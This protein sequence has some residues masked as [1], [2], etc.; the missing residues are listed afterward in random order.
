MASFV[1]TQAKLDVLSGPI[2]LIEISNNAGP[3]ELS[4]GYEHR[5]EVGETT[6]DECLK[7]A[8][9][10][11]LGGNGGNIL[12]IKGGFT[13]SEFF[14]EGVLPILSGEK[15]AEQLDLEFAYRSADYD[16]VGSNNT[17]KLGASWRPVDNLLVRVMQQSAT[18]A[19]NV[20]EIASPVV[21]GLSNALIDPCSIAN[22]ENIDA[23]LKA[24]CISTGMSDAQVGKVQDIISGQVNAIQGTNPDSLPEAEEATTFTAGF[25]YSNDTLLDLSLS[26]DYYDIEV[27]NTIGNFTAQQ[28]LNACYT[29]GISSE[30]DKIN[31]IGGDLTVSGSGIETYTTNLSYRR[32]E[33]IEVGLNFKVGLEDMGELKFDTSINHY[34]SNERQSSE[35]LAIIDCLGAYGNNC[36]PTPK[37]KWNQ[38]ITWE[39][40]DFILSALWRHTSGINMEE[41]QASGAYEAFRHIDSYDYVDLFGS[42]KYGEHI[43]LTFGVDNLFEKDAPI[44][45]NEAGSTTYN[46]GNTFPSSYSPL[47]R[48]YKAGLKFSF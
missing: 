35:Q 32:A 13:V 34:L 29:Y 48:I 6:P 15:F 24:L 44:V 10:S 11:C 30:C 9:S 31:R 47:G 43:V 5:K 8:P 28:T 42:Y 19:P 3:L 4:L 14:V 33:G 16:S 26:V 20:G 45:G 22:A 46:S 23:N 37:T 25:V 1:F 41:A 12:P 17:W 39:M 7:L 38:R 2:D 18:R 36:S 40:N 27:D 21:T